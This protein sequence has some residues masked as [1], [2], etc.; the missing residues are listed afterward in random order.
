M[1][2]Q[3][4]PA[5]GPEQATPE[6]EISRLPETA[7]SVPEQDELGNQAL[8]AQ[9]SG[10]GS[11]EVVAFDVVR[12]VAFPMVE[13]AILALQLGPPEHARIDRFLEI[14]AR[15]HLPEDRKQVLMDRLQTGRT[16]AVGVGEAVKRWFDGDS[17][18]VRDALGSALDAVSRGLE[19][20]AEVDGAWQMGEESVSLSDAAREGPVNDRAGA[21][22]SDLADGVAT[23]KPAQTGESGSFGVALRRFC[24]DVYLAIAFDEEEEEEEWGWGMAVEEG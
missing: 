14:L 7:I 1:G 19:E 8:Q 2:K 16:G 4:K 13:R 22:V 21:L 6:Q 9:M 11:D 12:D 10:E 18:E 3:K 23:E 5:R 24:R 20:G 17:E 15:S